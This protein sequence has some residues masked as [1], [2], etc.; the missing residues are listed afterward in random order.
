[1]R[2]LNIAQSRNT[3]KPGKNCC[4]LYGLRADRENLLLQEQLPA[5]QDKHNFTHAGTSV[6]AGQHADAC[7]CRRHVRD[8]VLADL[9]KKS[10]GCQSVLD[11][12]R[13]GNLMDPVDLSKLVSSRNR[14][15]YSFRLFRA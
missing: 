3:T 5:Q 4:T 15:Q 2:T 12:T 7:S 10:Y 11:V 8:S 13:T 14:L 6:K 9:Q 1:M